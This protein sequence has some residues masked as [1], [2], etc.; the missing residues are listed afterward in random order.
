VLRPPLRAYTAGMEQ[1]ELWW[2]KI[3]GT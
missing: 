3:A 2:E 1:R